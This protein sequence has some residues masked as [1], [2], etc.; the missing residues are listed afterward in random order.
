MEIA[1]ST[2][3]V[4]G[5]KAC[6]IIEFV[7]KADLSL[8]LNHIDFFVQNLNKVKAD[9]SIRPMAKLCEILTTSYFVKKEIRTKEVLSDKHLERMASACFD[10]LIGN[11]KVASKAYSMTSL[12]LLGE[13][14]PWIRPELKLVLEQDY[15][16][17][18]AAYKARA[19]QILALLKKKHRS[20]S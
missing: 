4:I 9:S 1:F 18:S 13:K 11:N 16:I 19:R 17:G 5:S 10:W 15:T 6:W 3:K 8:L 14:T 7:S 2:D 12:Y 20:S